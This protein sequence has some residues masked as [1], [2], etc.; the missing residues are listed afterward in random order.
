MRKLPLTEAQRM[1]KMLVMAD[2][3][4]AVDPVFK[5]LVTIELCLNF[6]WTNQS[7]MR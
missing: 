2:E 3:R 7:S 6:S 1:I 5:E 4:E